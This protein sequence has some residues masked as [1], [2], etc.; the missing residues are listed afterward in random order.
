MDTLNFS[1]KFVQFLKS[2]GQICFQDKLTK[3]PNDQQDHLFLETLFSKDKI[4]DAYRIMSLI[5]SF[6]KKAIA[7]QRTGKL[8]TYPS[9]LGQEAIGTAI[10]HVLSKDDIFTPYYRDIATQYLRGVSLKEILLYW[11]GS[12]LGSAYESCP[13]DFP[14]CVPIA[15]QLCHAAGAAVAIKT[16][17][18]HNAALVTC[19]EGATSKG[20][21]L[22]TLNLAGAWQLPLVVVV[23]NNQWA[24]STPRSIQCGAETIA[25]K[26]IGA[27]IHGV[28]VDGNDYFAVYSEVSKALKKA[29][30]GKGATLI[31]AMSYR[32]GDHTTADDASRYRPEPELKQA[33]LN[34][35]ILRY[36]RFLEKSYS[37]SQTD[38]DKLQ[39]SI[40]AEIKSSVD[41]YLKV[42]HQPP[43]A[44]FDHLYEFL[45]EAL[46]DQYAELQ[47]IKLLKINQKIKSEETIQENGSEKR[48]LL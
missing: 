14:I 10:G 41:E 35:P 42:A 13:K 18:E 31:E 22:E 46:L 21:F 16:R 33:W 30:V 6:D 8:G 32:L 25:Q 2:D 17:G 19:G 20:D 47:A 9:I 3:L 28:V 5:R 36:K 4:F 1:I 38:E 37:W 39:A 40:D 11:G 24:I 34:E 23:N 7:L 12:E 27:G 45:P 15:T 26:A 44:M 48:S 29:R 43:E